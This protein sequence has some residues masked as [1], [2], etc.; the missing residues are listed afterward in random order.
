MVTGS[1]AFFASGLPL[2]VSTVGVCEPC[3]EVNEKK[4]L[5]CYYKILLMNIR[6]ISSIVFL[7]VILLYLVIDI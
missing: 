5:W 2:C 4:C 6:N 3:I 1:G 7:E